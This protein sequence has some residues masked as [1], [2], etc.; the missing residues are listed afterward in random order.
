MD[1]ETLLGYAQLSELQAVIVSRGNWAAFAP[2]FSSKEWFLSEF[3]GIA[4]LRQAGAHPEQRTLYKTQQYRAFSSMCAITDRFHAETAARIDLIWSEEQS[5]TDATDETS[6]DDTTRATLDLVQK[7]FDALPSID[8]IGRDA[9]LTRLHGFW[10]D[11]YQR[12]IC[13]TGRGGVGKS[14]LVYSFVN[15]LLR[16][17]CQIHERP[18]PELVLSLTAKDNWIE[19]QVEAPLEQRFGSLRRVLEAFIDLCGGDAPRDSEVEELRDEALALARDMPCL[20][21]LDNLETLPDEELEALGTFIQRVPSPSKVIIT[22]RERRAFGERLD[23]RGLAPD[24]AVALVK[25]RAAND[26]VAISGTQNRAIRGVSEELNGVPLYLHFFANLLVT[27]YSA[28]EALQKIRGNDMLWLLRFSFDS[29][30]RSLN[31]SARELLYYLAHMPD[32]VTRSDLSQVVRDGEELDDAVG[33]LRSTHFIENVEMGSFRITDRQL[34]EYVISQFPARLGHEPALWIQRLTGAP[35]Q[36][37]PN[38]ERAIQQLVREANE[39]GVADWQRGYDRLQE[40]RAQFGDAN[41]IIAGLG[42][43]AFRLRYR[44]EARRLLERA[45]AGGHQDWNTHRT[46]GLVYYY[47][48]SLDEAIRQ[49]EISLTLRPDEPRSLLLLGDAMLDK[50]ARSAIA[51]DSSRRLEQVRTAKS[52]LARS[53]IEDDFARW[54]RW[55]N[56]RR[57]RLLEKAEALEESLATVVF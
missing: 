31:E 30:L 15:D 1:P 44:D 10:D 27:G 13:V 21:V 6:S 54:Q 41:E 46:L 56:E 48:R 28:S 3:R 57:A 32:P 12:S 18:R 25:A 33:R 16:R 53:L 29:S 49:A 9:E 26:G 52:A 35:A 19:G 38:I 24:A 7:N 22:D 45:I 37:H 42:Y 34:R 5:A 39:L 20:I 8:L 51:Q 36:A 55:H 40:G 14:A 4:A 11:D 43:F 47:D 23:L 2:Y 50:A 17:P